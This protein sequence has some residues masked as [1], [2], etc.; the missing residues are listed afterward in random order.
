MSQD[1]SLTVLYYSAQTA[2][3][4]FLEAV[5][6]Q[7]LKAVDGR[8]PVISVTQG[9]LAFGDRNIDVGRPGPSVLGIYRA[10]LTGAEAADTPFVA[11]AEDDTLYDPSHF[12]C[13]RPPLDTFAYNHNKW[14]LYT[15]WT[16]PIFSQKTNRSVMCQCIAPREQLIAALRERFDRHARD[17][18]DDR[19]IA[20]NFAEP[21]RYEKWLKVTEQKLET[22]RSPQPNIVISHEYALGW[23]QMGRKKDHGPIRQESVEPWGR[24]E[25]VLRMVMGDGA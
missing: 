23:S 12:D 4:P 3:P 22:F 11:M 10:I 19:R 5:R 25:D 2:P 6:N 14:A 15:W 16:P 20:L 13:H 18:Y 1:R 17:P 24:A 21:G 8:Y 9:P 7:L